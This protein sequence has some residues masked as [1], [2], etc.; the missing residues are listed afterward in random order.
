M[1]QEAKGK[2]IQE[3]A[4]DEINLLV[5][6]RTLWNGRK[7]VLITTLIF[8][9]LGLFIAVFTPKEYTATATLVPQV[10]SGSKLGGL[11]SL[12]AM[13]GFNMDTG[14]SSEISPV[15]YPRILQSLPFKL[16]L[17]DTKI[18]LN[19]VSQPISL[20]DYYTDE[21][22][23]KFN[24]LGTIKKYT[25]GLPGLLISAIR[26]KKENPISVKKSQNDII[27]LTNA[28]YEVLKSIGSRISLTADTKE[29]T[30]TLT[31]VMPEA[32]AS[33]QLGQSALNLLQNY[34]T[35][36]KIEKAREELDFIQQRFEVAK[37]EFKQVQAHLA[38]YRDRNKNISTSIA[39]AEGEQL[40]SEYQIAF[41]VYN[42]LAKQK[43][44]AR[45]K[46]KE[47]TPILTIIEPIAIPNVK[48]KPNKM[49]ILLM[50]TFLGGI[51]GI[52][53]VFLKANL[54]NIKTLW[55]ETKA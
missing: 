30:L 15:V 10:N 9:G 16:E 45:I 2:H 34:I 51:L 39:Q 8:M 28:K 24:L 36:Y 54:M 18:N 32:L 37:L 11:S 50:W 31:A 35:K 26:G 4:N 19:G 17:L 5:L 6:A 55:I 13:A 7:A 3:T 46:V 38:N 12:A 41:S 52:G 27:S 21:T 44:T 29:G 25:I 47:E 49:L 43:E 22:Y 33:A 42:E 14:N 40:Q 53:R 20:Y 23:Q 1:I 48:S